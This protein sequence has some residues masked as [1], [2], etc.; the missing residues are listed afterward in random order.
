MGIQVSDRTIRRWCGRFSAA[1]ADGW[2]SSFSKWFACLPQLF[3]LPQS[4]EATGERAM[5]ALSASYFSFM[6][7]IKTKVRFPEEKL[8]P[9]LWLW[10]FNH[11]ERALF[12]STCNG[13]GRPADLRLNKGPP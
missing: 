11:L 3:A 12:P 2:L 13:Q 5:L 4:M 9:K 6:E 8:L 10:G 7:E 1:V